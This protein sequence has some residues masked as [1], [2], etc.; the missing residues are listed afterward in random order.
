MV[1]VPEWGGKP[2]KN[3]LGEQKLPIQRVIISHTAAEGCESMVS[4]FIPHIPL[5][6]NL[7]P[8]SNS[9][10]PFTFKGGLL[11]P[12]QSGAVLSHGQ[13]GLGPHWL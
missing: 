8:S 3:K 12:C 10:H 2:A 1:K 5:S 6:M 11:R 9:I 4:K 13:L 7:S